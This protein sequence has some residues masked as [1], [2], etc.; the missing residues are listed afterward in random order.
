MTAE[1]MILLAKNEGFSAAVKLNMHA[2][3]FMEQ[4]RDMCRA[5]KC[6]AYGKTWR[7]P[8]AIGTVEDAFSRASAYKNGLLLQTTGTLEDEFD[9]ESME[10]TGKRHSDSFINFMKKIKN[11][12]PNALGMG[13]GTCRRCEK[14]TYPDAPCRFPEDSYSSMEAYGLWVSDVCEKSGLKYNYGRN[15]ITYVSCVLF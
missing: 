13:A 10:E 3:I 15:T 11:A 14:C 6:H 8:P 1:E 5:D 4:I 12:F 7:C 2:L 9:Y